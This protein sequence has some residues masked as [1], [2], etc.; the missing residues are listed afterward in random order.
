M[1]NGGTINRST[2][3]NYN[4]S[5]RLDEFIGCRIR[6]IT[7][8][9]VTTSPEA[10]TVTK[11]SKRMFVCILLSVAGKN[12]ALLTSEIT[13]TNRVVRKRRSTAPT[14]P[15]QEGGPEQR[16]TSWV[17]DRRRSNPMPLPTLP[18]WASLFPD[19]ETV[20]GSCGWMSQGLP[21]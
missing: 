19:P 11:L 6:I 9:G 1:T 8:S 18:T 10:F 3:H 16:L 13:L 14:R 12:N 2:R 20:S 7:G 15:D 21:R 5:N 17:L 4:K